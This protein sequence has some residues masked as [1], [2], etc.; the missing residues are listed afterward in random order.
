MPLPRG[1]M[2]KKDEASPRRY[3]PNAWRGD[4]SIPEESVQILQA[5]GKWMDGNGQTIYQSD[6][7]KVRRS[8]FANFTRS[9]N[10]L[11]VHAYFWPGSE[12]AVSG[13]RT[14]VKSAKLARTG[15][16][17]HVQRLAG[18]GRRRRLALA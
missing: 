4:G 7:C 18:D 13:L 11:Y 3:S 5:V 14:K 6:V 1:A 12:L 15:A 16:T 10:T 9:G 8:A 17:E 2:Q